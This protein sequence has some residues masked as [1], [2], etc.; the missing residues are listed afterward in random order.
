MISKKFLEFF[1]FPKEVLKGDPLSWERFLWIKKNLPSGQKRNLL[2]VGCGNGQ[3]SIYASKLGYTSL[4]LTWDKKDMY[5]AKDNLRNLKLKNCSF[6]IQDVRRLNER[7]DL[8][9]KFDVI[10]CT[11]NIEHIINDKKLIKNMNFCLKKNGILI[12]TTPSKDYIPL[13]EEDAGPFEN[14]ENG[15]HV[16]KGYNKTDLKNLTK[17]SDF[18]IL[19]FDYFGGYLSQKI[20]KLYR[21]IGKLNSKFA[22]IIIFPLKLVF[23]FFD[24]YITNKKRYPYYSIC[25]IAKKIK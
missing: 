1:G 25:L 8:F 23:S 13:G 19:N 16:R 24:D 3:F 21:K 18:K 6:E 10:L 4:G 12:L 2:D 9:N 17:L 14:I 7:K 5:K 22:W 15:N 20:T 11:E